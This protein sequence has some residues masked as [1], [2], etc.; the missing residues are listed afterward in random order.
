MEKEKVVI[1]KVIYSLGQIQCK[2]C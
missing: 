2:H 1:R